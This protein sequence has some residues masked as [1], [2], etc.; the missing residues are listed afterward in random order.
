MKTQL[1]I[2]MTSRL[3][4]ALVGVFLFFKRHKFSFKKVGVRVT[5]PANKKMWDEVITNYH[6]ATRAFQLS[7]SNEEKWG[8][9]TPEFVYSHD[10]VP[11]EMCS[12]LSKTVNDKGLAEVYDCVS[13]DKDAKRFCTLNLCAPMLLHTD[14][15]IFH[16]PMLFSMERSKMEMIGMIL[17]IDPNG[18]TGGLFFLSRKMLG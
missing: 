4:S 3:S 10:Q 12:S 2:S 5:K 7:E 8:Y 1:P 13:R 6:M 15:K 18:R 16:Q 14:E 9:T 11:I 17:M